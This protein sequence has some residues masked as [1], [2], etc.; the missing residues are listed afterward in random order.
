MFSAPALAPGKVTDQTF[1]Q[2][3]RRTHTFKCSEVKVGD[4]REAELEFGRLGVCLFDL[5]RHERNCRGDWS[6]QRAT[7]PLEVGVRGTG[8]RTLTINT[9]ADCGPPVFLVGESCC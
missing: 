2:K 3:F 7:I 9:P 4:L 1:V 5:G 8:V 6:L